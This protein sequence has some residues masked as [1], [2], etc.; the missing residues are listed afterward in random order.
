M[1]SSNLI[2]YSCSNEYEDYTYCVANYSASWQTLKFE[3]QYTLEMDNFPQGLSMTSGSGGIKFKD[4]AG[5]TNWTDQ[6]YIWIT[7]NFDMTWFWILSDVEIDYINVICGVSWSSKGVERLKT[8]WGYYLSQAQRN[9]CFSF[10]NAE[11][12]ITQNSYNIMPY[13]NYMSSDVINRWICDGSDWYKYVDKSKTNC[14][15]SSSE[16]CIQNWINNT[17]S[18]LSPSS[19]TEWPSIWVNYWWTCENFLNGDLKNYLGIFDKIFYSIKCSFE[20]ISK[21]TNKLIEFK[22]NFTW[23]FTLETKTFWP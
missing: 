23:F 15:N 3:I 4:S 6:P 11:F 21:F 5:W 10:R 14:L 20:S 13:I 16:E 2:D 22:D 18:S 8:W 1:T 19:N 12:H 7:S 17:P 9:L